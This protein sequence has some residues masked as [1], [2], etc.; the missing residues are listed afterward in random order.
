MRCHTGLAV[1]Y[2]SGDRFFASAVTSCNTPGAWASLALTLSL[3][4]GLR[5]ALA[6]APVTVLEVAV[7]AAL[8]LEPDDAVSAD[9]VLAEV[10]AIVRVVFVAVVAALVHLGLAVAADRRGVDAVPICLNLIGALR[11]AAGLLHC[12]A[13]HHGVELG[14]AGPDL[15][16][17]AAPLS[18]FEA[19]AV[20]CAGIQ[21]RRVIVAGPV[22]DAV[23]PTHAG[24][25]VEVGSALVLAGDALGELGLLQLTV[26]EQFLHP[27][28]G[29]VGAGAVPA[30]RRLRLSSGRN[31]FGV[32]R[33]GAVGTCIVFGRAGRQGEKGGEAQH[34]WFQ[35][36]DATLS[37][38]LSSGGFE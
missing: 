23:A 36:H 1:Y 11:Q 38:R 33:R 20:V 26:A 19:V 29:G 31:V 5:L 4:V 12:V 34:C 16:G 6:A 15:A 24:F 21:G 9:R 14:L 25:A 28:G 27:A 35:L 22:P 37:P 8:H 2:L 18:L 3:I 7:V 30:G 10:G 13:R 17:G 32:R